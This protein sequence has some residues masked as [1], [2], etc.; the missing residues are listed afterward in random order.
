M[1]LGLVDDVADYRADGPVDDKE[2]AVFS[3]EKMANE[4]GVVYADQSAFPGPPAWEHDWQEPYPAFSDRVVLEREPG[5]LADLPDFAR[6]PQIWHFACTE[7]AVDV[8]RQACGRDIN[9]F[10]HGVVGDVVLSFVQVVGTAPRID[11]ERSV[12][13]SFPTYELVQWPAFHEEDL[14]GLADRLFT[15]PGRQFTGVFAGSAVRAEITG[16]GLTGLRFV[17]V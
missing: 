8:L 9:V 5:E 14:P 3:V 4:Y 16:A 7:R 2:P 11:R 17:R 6:C 10:G 15:L 12:V 13:D 1:G